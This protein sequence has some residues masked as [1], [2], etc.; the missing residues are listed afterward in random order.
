MKEEQIR[1][2]IFEKIK[3]LYALKNMMH[4]SPALPSTMPVGSMM[5][6]NSSASLMPLLISGSPPDGMPISLKKTWLPFSV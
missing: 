1:K 5:K 3:Q 6:K 2:E 4:L